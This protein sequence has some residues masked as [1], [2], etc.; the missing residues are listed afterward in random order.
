MVGRREHVEVEKRGV[1][2]DYS[3]DDS[4]EILRVTGN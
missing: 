1:V 2:D 3:A 4:C